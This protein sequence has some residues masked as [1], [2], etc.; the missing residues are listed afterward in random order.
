MS[1]VDK[2]P[3][4]N[5]HSIRNIKFALPINMNKYELAAEATVDPIAR[6]AGAKV[7]LGPPYDRDACIMAGSSAN[8]MSVRVVK[9]DS[10]FPVEV[11]GKIIARDEVDY[12]CVF[13]FNCERN[14]AQL[15][16]S[17]IKGKGEP[18]NDAQF[19]KGVIQ[20]HH[21]PYNKRVI[22]QLPSFK[23][24]VK[25]VLQNV[26]F[27]VAPSVEVTVLKKQPSDAIVHLDGKTTVGTS[28][29]YRHHMVLYDSG[30]PSGELVRENGSLVLN[31]N[32]LAVQ[33]LVFDP[34]FQEEEQ[35]TLYFCFLDAGS[36]IEDED[37]ISTEEE[38]YI[39]SDENDVGD[40]DIG[41]DGQDG[42]EECCD[43]EEDHKNIV[44]LKYPASKIT[45]ENL[46]HKL[47]L[48]VKWS[49]ILAA[50]LDEEFMTR[51]AIL[52]KGYRS[53]N[54]RWGPFFE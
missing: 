9:A 36:E 28:R 7:L 21:N 17:E 45:W 3:E 15:I 50:P 30:L 47:E 51:R 40:G 16:N 35:M 54:Y 6:S 39:S 14:D 11:Y 20:Y 32:L 53:P 43:E 48:E 8:V 5:L 52:P 25:L 49:A 41:L 24:T 19:S 33:R 29:N 1:S 10:G 18:D 38:D 12:K 42:Q 37:Y 2:E 4:K 46:S 26:A 31:R 13:L 27:P 23:S 22:N 44:T 34:A